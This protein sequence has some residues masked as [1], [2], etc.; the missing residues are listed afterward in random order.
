VP[1]RNIFLSWAGEQSPSHLVAQALRY[2][3]PCFSSDLR[4]WGTFDLVPGQRWSTELAAKL[5]STEAG[6]LC[7]TAGNQNSRWLNFE[8]GAL[9]RSV[10]S[11]QVI[12]YA[13]GP[14][15][16]PITDPIGQFQAVPATR[17][18]TRALLKA[19]L[20]TSPDVEV[21][22]PR[23]FDAFWPL[24]E[25]VI[26]ATPGGQA[27]TTDDMLIEIRNV[28]EARKSLWL[29]EVRLAPTPLHRGET[30]RI[31]YSIKTTAHGLSLWL[32]ASLWIPGD[33]PI[34]N[35]DQDEVIR[36]RR[37]SHRYSRSL[38]I[39]PDAPPGDYK[40]NAEVWYGP[41]SDSDG[42]YP[43]QGQWPTEHTVQ[44]V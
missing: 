40:L 15:S 19:L 34:F 33:K 6:V 26:C 32:G 38:T 39:P 28:Y 27:T 7:L 44:I 10:D 9:A 30:L 17:E 24:L 20:G 25:R 23:M 18:G 29:Q 16:A 22:D 42:S 13:I 35:T 8:A 3:L 4:P 12:P 1:Y 5:T 21:P 37:G 41:T 31:D 14:F 36:V 2:W 43:L 11:A